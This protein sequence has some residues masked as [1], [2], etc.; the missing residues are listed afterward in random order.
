LNDPDCLLLGESTS[1]T[2]EEVIS[3]ASIIAMTC[4]M[5][6]LS[7]DLTKVS[8]NRMKI[9]TQIFPMTGVSGVVLDLH[10]TKNKGLPS[11][12]RLWCTDRYRHLENFRATDSFMQSLQEEDFNAEATYFGRQAAFDFEN[13][14]AVQE[15]IRSCIHVANGMGTW[16]VVSVS[17]WEDQPRVMHVPRVAIYS[18]PETGWGA[19]DDIPPSSVRSEDEEDGVGTG[20]HVFAF[21]SGRYKW[22]SIKGKDDD[23][24]SPYPISQRLHTHETEI[25]HIK[26]VTPGKPQYVGS[27]LHFSCGH[28]VLSFDTTEKNKVKINLKTELSRVGH[29]FLFIPTV[30]TSHVNVSVA[31]KPS[32]WSVIGNVPDDVGP[33]HCCGRIIRL[34]VVIHSDKSEKDGEVVVDY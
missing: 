21:W 19:H 22:I 15:R 30:D 4:G 12:M 29:V 26:K 31:G 10:T 25:F 24:S 6:L 33:S 16:T 2:N 7:D 3:A 27:D 5:M 28:E 14:S 9:L 18:P 34:M 13:V 11:L 8:L 1:L 32:R 23:D 17:N 20:Y